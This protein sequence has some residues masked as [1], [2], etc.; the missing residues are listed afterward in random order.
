MKIAITSDLHLDANP[1]H[2]Y[3]WRILSTLRRHLE[4]VDV[5]GV[6]IAGDMTHVKDRHPAEFVNSLVNEIA[7][8][9]AVGPVVIVRGRHDYADPSSPFFGFLDHLPGVTFVSR[10]TRCDMAGH[11]VLC[12]PHGVSWGMNAQ[13]RR[14]LPT[15]GPKGGL[16]SWDLVVM[17]EAVAGATASPGP[18]PRPIIDGVA[19]MQTLGETGSALVVSGGLHRRQRVDGVEYPGAPHRLRFGDDYEPAMILVDSTP[20][21]MAAGHVVLGGIRRTVLEIGLDADLGASPILGDG[22]VRDGDHVRARIHS[23]DCRPLMRETLESAVRGRVEGAGAVWFGAEFVRE[24]D[25]DGSIT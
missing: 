25:G 12:I 24:D 21:G 2:A 23:K 1:D 3:R 5:G 14:E 4:R 6:I 20:A 10:P 7:S 13:W 18:A 16:D 17:H 19:K 9:A 8:L 15:R 11:S 22:V